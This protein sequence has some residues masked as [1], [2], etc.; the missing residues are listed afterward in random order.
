MRRV[1]ACFGELLPNRSE[2]VERYVLRGY[3]FLAGDL[4]LL[5][6]AEPLRL[7]PEELEAA[8][9]LA[10]VF[11]AEDFA[12]GL[13]EDFAAAVLGFAL[14]LAPASSSPSSSSAS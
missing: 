4:A 14:D 13:A 7:A 8:F 6:L 5:A 9:V 12:A 1:P 11:D 2:R 3:F 10:G